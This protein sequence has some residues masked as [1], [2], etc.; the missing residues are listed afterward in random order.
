M[1]KKHI[2]I[3]VVWETTLACNM[4]CLHCGSSAGKRRVKELS[5]DESMKLCD[6]L[7]TLGT[8]VI[9]MMGGEPFLRKDWEDIAL[10]IRDLNMNLTFMSNGLLI[11]D[12]IITKLKKIDPYA[13]TISIDGATASTHNTIRG[14]KKSFEGAKLNKNILITSSLNFSSLSANLSIFERFLP[15]FSKKNSTKDNFNLKFR[16]I[17]FMHVP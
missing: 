14:V 1:I 10:Y 15:C 17:F 16:I 12:K 4:N 7:K 6:D 8:R 2:P 3:S 9:S 5:T 13:V 11:D